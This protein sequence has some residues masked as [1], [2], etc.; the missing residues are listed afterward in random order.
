MSP[1]IVC[2]ISGTPVCISELTNPFP[3]V[4]DQYASYFPFLLIK[5]MID[6]GL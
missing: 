4:F 5:D 2:L 6:Q 1:S 3:L